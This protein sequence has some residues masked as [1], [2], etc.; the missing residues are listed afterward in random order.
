MI[1]FL[2]ALNSILYESHGSAI[3]DRKSLLEMFA[4]GEIPAL[5]KFNTTQPGLG[6]FIDNNLGLNTGVIVNYGSAIS[7]QSGIAIDPSRKISIFIAGNTN[8]TPVREILVDLFSIFNKSISD[9]GLPIVQYQANKDL[10]IYTQAEL[11][12]YDGKYANSNG[13]IDIHF[14]NDSLLIKINAHIKKSK[15]ETFIKSWDG[16]YSDGYEF[17]R[18]ANINGKKFLLFR[19]SKG[20]VG[21]FAQALPDPYLIPSHLNGITGSYILNKNSLNLSIYKGS[22]ANNQK[23]N[24]CIHDGIL[25][26]GSSVLIVDTNQMGRTFGPTPLGGMARS[27][28][29]VQLVDQKKLIYNNIDFIKIDQGVLNACLFPEK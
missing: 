2:R 11:R 21:L 10:K 13:L 22:I 24:L 17:I 15:I 14:I 27:N 9:E 3:V 18:P 5:D 7:H 23:K 4:Y 29:S 20:N 25:M 28:L 12:V 16:W 26:F 1:T 19:D 8:S 6:V